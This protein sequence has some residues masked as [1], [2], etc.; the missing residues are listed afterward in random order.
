MDKSRKATL[1]GGGIGN[2]AAAA[3]MVRDVGVDGRNITIL[4]ALP[5]MGGSLDAGGNAASGYSLRGGR[6]LTTANYECTWDLFK[7]IPSLTSP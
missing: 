4:D 1:I 3:F 2:L 6:M 5:V 7:T